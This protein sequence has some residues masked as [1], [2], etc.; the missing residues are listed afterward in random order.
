MLP[1]TK[2]LGIPFYTGKIVGLSQEI[3]NLGLVVV[4]SAPV[5]AAM[6]RDS[7]HRSAVQSA[8]VAIA[9][10]GWMVILWFLLTGVALP[11][12]SGLRFL[13]IVLRSAEFRRAGA[14]FWVMPSAPDAAANRAWLRTQ[15]IHLP[16]TRCYI[17]PRYPRSG[18]IT[19][20][21]LL[22]RIEESRPAFVV[23]CLG[24]GVQERLGHYL[25]QNLSYRP[26][27][28]CIGAAIAFLS[29]QQVS[30]PTWADRLFLGWLFR[31]V[32][33]PQLY[34]PRYWGSLRLAS[35]LVRH[36][37]N[38]PELTASS[39]ATA[40]SRRANESGPNG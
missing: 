8:D 1:V 6:D 17:A 16:D 31:T 4:P 27:I 40:I 14:S 9:D 35:L 13:E 11:R 36:R 2:I 34:F 20:R 37:E 33:N 30:I 5:L 18:E 32:S 39:T 10:S 24:G 3:E 38:S 15:E 23:L 28:I 25:R 7:A 19:D 26:T 29:G 21:A 12:I 22:G